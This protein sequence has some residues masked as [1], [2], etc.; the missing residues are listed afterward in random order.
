MSNRKQMASGYTLVEIMVASVILGLTVAGIVSLLRNG[1]ELEYQNDHRRQARMLA[2]KALEDPAYFY[3]SYN[4]S[5][6]GLNDIGTVLF[7]DTVTNRSVPC[8]LIVT[9]DAEVS[10]SDWDNSI[11]PDF[12]KITARVRW[13]ATGTWPDGPKEEVVLMK[14]VTTVR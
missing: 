4:P 5:Y 7:L 3:Y 10:L 13:T 6:A 8:S 11:R 2:N 9:V 1:R 12:R 14:R